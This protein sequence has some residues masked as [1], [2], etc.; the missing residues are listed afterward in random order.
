MVWNPT[1]INRLLYLLFIIALG[2]AVYS[3]HDRFPDLKFPD[4][5]DYRYLFVAVI[6]QVV[7]WITSCFAWLQSLSNFTGCRFSF[8]SG[9]IQSN[10]VTIGKYLPGK[11]WGLVSRGIDLKQRGVNKKETILVSYVDQLLLL[12]AGVI[13]GVIS[14]A[15]SKSFVLAVIALFVG[16][17][18]VLLIPK[19][20]DLL[21]RVMMKFIKNLDIK[22][23]KTIL[24]V[25][26]YS[27]LIAYYIA[28]W[29]A[30]GLIFASIYFVFFDFDSRLLLPLIAANAIGIVAGFIAVFAPG[31]LGVREAASAGILIDY[32]PL[33]EA[34][35]LVLIYRLWTVLTDIT[36]GIFAFGLFHFQKGSA[37]IDKPEN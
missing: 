33:E 14:I 24:T 2:F 15:L 1:I 19:S 36:G 32:I 12:H 30:A 28:V 9:F 6:G 16:I 3:V 31:G 17:L 11:I 35:F 23:L 5:P 25:K 37:Q 13:V 8:I 21:A 22:K 10:I 34:V 4:D 27:I 26:K 20:H 7:F 29:L 18:S